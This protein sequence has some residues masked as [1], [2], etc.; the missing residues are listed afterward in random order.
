MLLHTMTGVVFTVQQEL[1]LM[2]ITHFP[3][4]LTNVRAGSGGVYNDFP[5]LDQ[6]KYYGISQW[7]NEYA[8]GNYTVTGTGAVSIV[9]GKGG[10]LTL[11]N[12]ATN[13]EN[14]FLQWKG[15]NSAT[16]EPFVFEAGKKLVFKTR[17]KVNNS[18]NASLVFGLQKTDTTP[19][20]VSD[21]VYFLKPSGA[22]AVNLIL[23]NSSTLTT[24]SSVATIA[25]DTFIEIGF[26]YDGGT[27][28]EV[29]VNGVKTATQTTLTNLP[30]ANLT[31][32]YGVQNASAVSR[33][34]T[35]N[36]IQ[37]FGEF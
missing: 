12:S 13:S 32:S 22:G 4:G 37:A 8:S 10:L 29:Y 26:F 34:M 15:G 5:N 36:Y 28:V 9:S 1:N 35:L 14:T 2:A 27:K 18:N 23:A 3:S 16:I 30:T 24:L 33:V 20:A 31:L 6:T 17:L 25:D 19:L 11:T 7:G 21:G